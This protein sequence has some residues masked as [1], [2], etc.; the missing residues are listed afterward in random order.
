VNPAAFVGP[1]D[2]RSTEG[3]FVRSVLERRFPVV[4]VQN[5]CVIDVRDMAEAI[6]HALAQEMY[7][8]PIPLAGHNVSLAELVMRTSQL[9]GIPAPPPFPLEPNLVSAAA[10]WMQMAFAPIS[11]APL[12][13]LSFIPVITDVQP[14]ARSAEQETL[15]VKIRPLDDS[16]R[17]GISFHRNRFRA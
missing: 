4:L 12:A 14:M 16:L 13:P 8:R 3:S 2:F 15:G 5:M 11:P 7:G 1:W 10:Y 17:D 6:D 9:A